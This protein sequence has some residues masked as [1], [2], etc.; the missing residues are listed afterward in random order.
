MTSFAMP[1]DFGQ[2]PFPGRG[3][4]VI[5]LF[6]GF[7][8]YFL[9]GLA[10]VTTSGVASII[11]TAPGT[12]ID[13]DTSTFGFTASSTD[14][15]YVHSMGFRIP[16]AIT[17]GAGTDLIKFAA[18]AGSDATSASV[19]AVA[20]AAASS[21]T[22][23][24]QAVRKLISPTGAIAITSDTTFRLWSADV[25]GSTGVAGGNISR[26]A[27]GLWIPCYVIYSKHMPA[28]YEDDVFKTKTQVDVEV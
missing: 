6:P 9:Y 12:D 5:H 16:S 27:G 19:A 21:G 17:V 14:P 11:P 1:G 18:A 4:G 25:A 26:S 28:L 3:D 13:T 23:A 15:A 24:A 8:T 22:L 2:I 10:R 20:S 7:T